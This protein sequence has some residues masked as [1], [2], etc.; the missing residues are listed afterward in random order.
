MSYEL[1][2]NDGGFVAVFKGNVTID[3]LNSANG[4]MHGHFDFDNH[5]YQ[6]VD[7][8]E[9]NL[10][11][12]CDEDTEFPAVT[13]SIASETTVRKVKVAFVVEESYALSIVN[14]YVEHARRLV[15][16]WKFGV[17]ST[18]EVAFTWATT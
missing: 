6:I 10:D 4:E 5:R 18:P 13:D 9:A 14:G 3:E 17:F 11:S 8:L 1:R 15:P 12:V 16:K 7:L 2:Y